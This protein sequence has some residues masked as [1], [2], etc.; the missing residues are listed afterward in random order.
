MSDKLFWKEKFTGNL[1]S[2][3]ICET[4]GIQGHWA[5]A[6]DIVPLFA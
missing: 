6:K 4:T 3:S 2:E 5:Y 1:G